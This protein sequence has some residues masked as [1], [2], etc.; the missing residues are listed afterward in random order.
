MWTVGWTMGWLLCSRRDFVV[1]KRVYTSSRVTGFVQ[2]VM[3]VTK[4]S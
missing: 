2:V 1:S 4:E 3:V